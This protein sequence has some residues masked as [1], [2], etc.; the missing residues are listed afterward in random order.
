VVFPVLRCNP[1]EKAGISTAP[2]AIWERV[3]AFLRAFLKKKSPILRYYIYVVYN[4]K[5]LLFA[6]SLYDLAKI[7]KKTFG[8]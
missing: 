2:G 4:P 7:V 3:V 8:C 1:S 6:E 5:P